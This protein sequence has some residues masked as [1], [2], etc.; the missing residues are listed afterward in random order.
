MLE[1]HT[2]NNTIE[3]LNDFRRS[4]VFFIDWGS[5][6]VGVNGKKFV[7][8]SSSD[9]QPATATAWQNKYSE[10]C[11][12]T[13]DWQS[14]EL[15]SASFFLIKDVCGLSDDDEL[16]YTD[17]APTGDFSVDM[18]YHLITLL[19]WKPGVPVALD[20]KGWVTVLHE[21]ARCPGYLKHAFAF[22][23][24]PNQSPNDL[25]HLRDLHQRTAAG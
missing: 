22:L 17:Y 12:D 19:N 8:V 2:E 1:M 16:S 6:H 21:D 18:A 4:N 20:D 24:M 7:V 13:G 11:P 3:M 23:N 14:P 15:T 25:A 5:Q 10:S 9:G